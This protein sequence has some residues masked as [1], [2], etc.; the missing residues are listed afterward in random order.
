MVVLSVAQFIPFGFVPAALVGL[1]FGYGAGGK[2]FPDSGAMFG[3]RFRNYRR[4]KNGLPPLDSDEAPAGR[5]IEEFRR[6]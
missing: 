3:R 5:Y 4:L 2:F 6:G 1:A